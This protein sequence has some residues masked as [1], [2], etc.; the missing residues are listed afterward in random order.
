MI[1]NI[2]PLQ[3]GTASPFQSPSLQEIIS[4]AYINFGGCELPP[5]T[6]Q[7]FQRSEVGRQNNTEV[8]VAKKTL[9]MLCYFRWHTPSRGMQRYV[10]RFLW[11]GRRKS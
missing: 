2:P 5:K 1:P 7:D 6:T 11:V 4:A 9:K 3:A 8:S 10:Q